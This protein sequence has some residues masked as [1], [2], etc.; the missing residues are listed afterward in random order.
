M[1]E[2]NVVTIP[3]EELLVIFG[4]E[5]EKADDILDA[6]YMLE[7]QTGRTE[8]TELIGGLATALKMELTDLVN[9][10]NGPLEEGRVI[11]LIAI[12][13]DAPKH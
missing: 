10:F 4:L 11:H 2:D 12:D 5:R 1:N 13:P 8:L 6:C 9:I 7:Q 3:K